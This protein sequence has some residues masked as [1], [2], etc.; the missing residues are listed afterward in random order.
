[1]ANNGRIIRVDAQVDPR[2][3]PAGLVIA[4]AHDAGYGSVLAAQD[5]GLA[6][7]AGTSY[8]L[9]GTKW[10][11]AMVRGKGMKPNAFVG[12]V[13]FD[14]RLL[15]QLP[16]EDYKSDWRW[17]WWREAIQNAVDAGAKN[18]A[19]SIT[20]VT[21]PNGT[22]AVDVVCE[23]DG[24]G[25]SM[26]VL[27][28]K[29]LTLGATGKST[30]EY[31]VSS[32]GFGKAKELLLFCW[33]EWEV[34]T[35]NAQLVGHGRKIGGDDNAAYKSGTLIRA[36]MPADQCTSRYHLIQALQ[37]CHLPN[38]KVS[39]NGDRLDAQLLANTIVTDLDNG[40]L[41]VYRRKKDA[42]WSQ[43]SGLIVRDRNGI[44][45]FSDSVPDGVREYV[46]VVMN[47]PSVEL[48]TSNRLQL[49]GSAKQSL[50]AFLQ[51]LAKDTMSALKAK[52]TK[53]FTVYKGRGKFQAIAPHAVKAAIE[54]QLT[55]YASKKG[56]K[57]LSEEQKRAI[58]DAIGE[59]DDTA[60]VDTAAEGG[61]DSPAGDVETRP[62]APPR[63]GLDMRMAP[64]VLS[65]MLDSVDVKGPDSIESMAAILAWEPDFVVVNEIEGYR[66]PA[67]FV[68]ATMSP[69]LRKLAR[70]W[71][72]VIR[73]LMC[74]LGE[75]REYAVGWHFDT[76]YATGTG[77]TLASYTK[78]SGEHV[79]MLNPFRTGDPKTEL[80]SLSNKNDVSDIVSRAMHE[81]THCVY[82]ISGH[83]E[84]FAA[85]M[86]YVVKRAGNVWP[87][88]SK[89]RAAVVARG[90]KTGAMEGL[91]T[92]ARKSTK[93]VV[94]PEQPP[95]EVELF[96]DPDVTQ[97]IQM[98]REVS[99][100]HVYHPG[101]DDSYETLWPKSGWSM[102]IPDAIAMGLAEAKRLRCRSARVTLE[103]DVVVLRP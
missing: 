94:A 46:V 82:G 18:I 13:G 75:S 4:S 43:W 6:T 66:V 1:M 56:K 87:Q 11:A 49:T 65:A 27:L 19:C 98:D 103:R 96:I 88:V 63:V 2:D 84:E 37:G 9:D 91:D 55:G 95:R 86:S 70:F 3:L 31:G 15:F 38:V 22:K 34:Y 68:P 58:T 100:A 36:R 102:T 76:S 51:K 5:L 67:K 53:Q 25:M 57:G 77:Y 85:S 81:I 90:A 48:L 72:E 42:G 24:R 14:D 80:L 45:M 44:K 61:Y 41:K 69:Q 39:L 62:D 89:L 59:I 74:R 83:D 7:P 99:A 101:I 92:Q 30:D 26:D 32:G 47:A 64:E 12:E 29:F 21:L 17:C 71:A 28:Q 97:A 93:R 40:R 20:D 60:P 78:H 35:R 54:S 73:M 33:I 79:L 16:F 8:D 52:S 23:D 10:V 50:T